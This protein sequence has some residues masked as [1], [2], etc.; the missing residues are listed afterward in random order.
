MCCMLSS[1][2]VSSRIVA[3]M[4]ESAPLLSQ[5]TDIYAGVKFPP[6]VIVK[7]DYIHIVD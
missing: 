5:L 2:H 1:F 4:I 6:R 7:I 3:D